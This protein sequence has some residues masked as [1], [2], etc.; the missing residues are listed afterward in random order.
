MITFPE[1]WIT[2]AHDSERLGTEKS[3]AFIEG[4]AAACQTL[5]MVLTGDDDRHGKSYD[6]MTIKGDIMHS[7]VFNM[8]DGGRHHYMKDYASV[9]EVCGVLLTE[10]VEWIREGTRP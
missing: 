7:Y 5:R 6:P 10:T 3:S 4:F 2:E 9:R 8:K 1:L